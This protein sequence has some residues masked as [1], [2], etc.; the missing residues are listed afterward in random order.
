MWR[1]GHHR[2]AIQNLQGAI[3]SN[4]FQS[5]DSV[6]VD[7]SVNTTMN[8]HQVASNNKVKC[9]AQLLLAKWLDRAGQT[10]ALALKDAYASGIM[11]FPRWDKGHYYLGRHYLKLFES[12]RLLPTAKQSNV[13]AAGET[14]KLVIENYIR[15]VVYGTKHYYQ[16]IPK[17]LTLWLNMGMDVLN[18]PPRTGR[19]K[20]MYDHKVNFLDAINRHIKRY[21]TERMPAF[22]WYTAFPQ[23]ITRISHPHKIV[24]DVLQTIILKV[25]SNYPQQALWSLLAVT[26][27]TQDD[28]RA[29]GTAVLHKLKGVGDRASEAHTSADR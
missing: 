1:E 4:A 12:E 2:K 11:S 25:A 26:R 28:R 5:R 23:I 29:R 3:Q 15:S 7:V 19:E 9:H 8:E 16:T 6:P 22:A 10:K 13:Y 24:W 20:E 14:A 21:T 18:P 17:V 27:A